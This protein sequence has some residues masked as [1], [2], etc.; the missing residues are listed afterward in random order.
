MT[1]PDER[2]QA[3]LSARKLL[4]DL[5]HATGHL[6]TDAFRR[7]AHTVLRHFPDEHHIAVSAVALPHIWGE[8]GK[9]SK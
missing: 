4:N 7:R 6:T 3:V 2:S 1:M 9:L 5:A 8:I